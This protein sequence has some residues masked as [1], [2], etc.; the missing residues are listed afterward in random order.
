MPTVWTPTQVSIRQKHR[1]HFC[2]RKTW[3]GLCP[4]GS[5]PSQILHAPVSPGPGAKRA[6]G[7]SAAKG[8]GRSAIA[9]CA[10]GWCQVRFQHGLGHTLGVLPVFPEVGVES[11]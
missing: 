9:N 2:A 11:V 10:S 8:T 5:L 6:T 3:K 7:Q 1:K 4:P